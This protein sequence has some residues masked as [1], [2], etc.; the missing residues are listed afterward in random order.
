MA[1]SFEVTPSVVVDK[2]YL[3]LEKYANKLENSQLVLAKIQFELEA[4]GVAFE[5]ECWLDIL[6]YIDTKSEGWEDV[7]AAWQKVK[8][9]EDLR[10]WR[11]LQAWAYRMTNPAIMLSTMEM[12]FGD[13]FILDEW[14]NIFDPMTAVWE[15][16]KEESEFIQ[17]AVQNEEH[18]ISAPSK[19]SQK[20]RKMK[21]NGNDL[22]PFDFGVID[23]TKLAQDDDSTRASPLEAPQRREVDIIRLDSPSLGP[24][25]QKMGII[26][27]SSTP[28]PSP[29]K[30][31][32][33]DAGEWSIAESLKVPHKQRKHIPRH[34]ASHFLDL[35]AF[36]EDEDE[37]DGENGDNDGEGANDSDLAISGPSETQEVVRGGQAAFA[38]HLD[39]IC[40]QYEEN[41]DC[42]APHRSPHHS[43]S[44]LD[45][46]PTIRVYKLDI[47]LGMN[48]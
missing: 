30:K 35:S 29:S 42:N 34:P 36:N 41:A 15:A 7:K 46:G 20:Q 5:E 39:N 23:L 27:C 25:Q 11:L 28:T 33:R 22:H 45:S 26:Q 24:L 4:V 47:L 31:H 16:S 17:K 12:M 6:D 9:S 18:W 44:A 43:Q 10:A 32:Q 14:V 2:A 1:T 40:R 8:T 21:P 3:W 13:R 38:S 19:V 37:D 48:S